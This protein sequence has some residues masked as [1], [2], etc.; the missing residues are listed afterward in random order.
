MHLFFGIFSAKIYRKDARYY[1]PF[2]ARNLILNLK[3]EVRHDG[4]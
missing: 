1:I 3:K 2:L 4:E